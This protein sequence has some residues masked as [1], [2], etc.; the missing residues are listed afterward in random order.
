V[1]QKRY[2][3]LKA[4]REWW[5]GVSGTIDDCLGLLRQKCHPTDAIIP[6]DFIKH[7]SYS[8]TPT[9]GH[10]RFSTP[11]RGEKETNESVVGTLFCRFS[12]LSCG[13][14]CARPN[15]FRAKLDGCASRT[16]TA[17]YALDVGAFTN[18][19]AA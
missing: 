4:E 12:V 3:S 10:R 11:Q 8:L 19:G 2:S 17:A 16:A 18:R 13:T 1:H 15:G 14:A 7:R 9:G 5:S 6:L